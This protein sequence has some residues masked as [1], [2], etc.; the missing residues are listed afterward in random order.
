MATTNFICQEVAVIPFLWMLPLALY[1]LS[2]VFCFESDRWYR[3]ALFHALFALSA[4]LV[5]L[6]LVPG[7]NFSIPMQITVCCAI[8]FTA[9]MV[10]HGEAARLRPH[11]SQLTGF[12]VAISAGG[13]LGGV[14][15]SLIAPHVFFD[16]WEFPLGIFACAGLLLLSARRDTSSWWYS[17]QWAGAVAVLAA[18]A[19]LIPPVLGPVWTLGGSIPA[20]AR[21]A[22]SA[23]LFGVAACLWLRQRSAGQSRT[24]PLGLRLSAYLGLGLLLAGLAIP[25][26]YSFFHVVARSR[27]FYVVLAIVDVQPDNYLVL[28]HGKTVHGLQFHDPQLAKIPTGYY[29]PRSGANLVLRNWPQHPMRVGLLGIGVGT[30]A[31]L[32]QP[33]DVYRFYEINPDVVRWS[34]ARDSYFTYLKDSPGRIEVVLGDGRL[35]ME[36]EASR[37]ELQRFDVL[38]LDAFSSDAIPM[39]LLTREAFAIYEQHL[40]GP[41]SVIAVHISNRAI[42]LLPV[43]AGLARE[44]QYSFVHVHPTWLRGFSSQ[45]DWILLSKDAA[46]LRAPD[47]VQ[48]SVPYGNTSR[49]ILWTDDYSDLMHVLR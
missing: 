11:A 18:I 43:V 49:T 33:G 3:P 34:T 22:V 48:L 26:K 23:A 27:N 10:C 41:R 42:D 16:Y 24:G 19:Y 46:L 17:G 15:V 39:H 20:G 47:L 29:G 6:S 36:R 5:V 35:S 21:L 32:A 8:L 28:Q 7:A 12:Y 1:L 13:A 14:S 25:Q 30:L 38:V 44:F 4:G 31:A 2:F 40:R 37:G 9:C 45:A